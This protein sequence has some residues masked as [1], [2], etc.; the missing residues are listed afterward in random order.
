MDDFQAVSVV[1]W[2]LRPLVAG[3]D[4]AVEFD[5]YPVRLHAEPRDE[6]AQGLGG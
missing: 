1:Q 4:L 3:H 6:R 5:C 2:S